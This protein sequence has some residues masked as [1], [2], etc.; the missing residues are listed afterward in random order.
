MLDYFALIDEHIPPGP[1][2]RVYT[3]HVT[4]VTNLA[5]KIADRMDLS[6]KEKQFIEEATMLHDIGI[7]KTHAPDIHCTGKLPYI[8]HIIEGR[9]ILEDAG[10]PA[11]ARVAANHIGVGGLSKKEIVQQNLPLPAEDIRCESKAEKII[12][13][14]DLFYSKKPHKLFLKKSPK[15]LL[16]KYA[17]RPKQLARFEKWYKRYGE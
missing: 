16:D 15:E 9:K 5:L 1:L 11:H 17:N 7:Y 14:A 4:L 10:L 3:I 13:Y 8:Q 2:Y 6:A 12:S